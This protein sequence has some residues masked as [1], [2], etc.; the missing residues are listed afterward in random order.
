MKIRILGWKYEHIR[1]MES[2][3]VS[4]EREDGEIYPHSLIMMP[5]GT[6]KTTTLYLIRAAL[7]GSAINWK[8]RDVISY[9][10]VYSQEEEGGFTLKVAFGEDIYYYVL[11]LDYESGRAWYETGSAM[12]AGGLEEGWRLPLALR[13]I[14]N[15]EGFVNRFIFDGEQARKTL[16]TGS[17]EAENSIVYL[18]QL[19]KLTDL[20]EQVNKVVQNVQEQNSGGATEHSVKIFRSRAEKRKKRWEDLGFEEREI[21][22]Q[23]ESMEAENQRLQ[24]AYQEILA[25]DQQMQAEQEQL[26][27]EQERI[28]GEKGAVVSMLTEKMRR[29]YNLQLDIHTRMKALLENMQILK[30]P[31]TTAREFFKELADSDICVCGRPIGKEEKSKILENA[32]K[33]LGQDE[34]IAVNAIK[35][36][37]RE[38]ERDTDLEEL[39]GRLQGLM[40]QE[41]QAQSGL[42]RLTTVLADKGHGEI[43][44]IK[45]KLEK[46]EEE[47]KRLKVQLLRLTTTDYISNTGLN[48]DNNIPLAQK[49]WRE[50]QD[51]FLKASGTYEFTRKAERLNSYIGSVKERTL[52][53]LKTYLVRET[54]ER[55]NTLI[56]NDRILI[57][58]IDGHLVLEGKEGASEGQTLALAY[59]YIGTLF[60]HSRFEFPFLVDS[61]AAAMDLDV[62]REVAE[63]LPKLFGQTI[64]F[65]TSGEKSGFVDTFFERQDVHYLTIKGTKDEAAQCIPG[66]AFFEKYQEKE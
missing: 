4:L 63:V 38:Y 35:N 57:K 54:N 22:R 60:A 34:L 41:H 61:P 62:R 28:K 13:G 24:Q 58:R 50:A 20:M 40:E 48:A 17:Q 14:L 66:R 37:L 11:H 39:E 31:K 21:R 23:L 29:P 44:Q 12:M 9:R 42:N 33:Y 36:A 16:N 53:K 25:Q 55:L 52:K 45:E 46:L 1:R 15:S 5:N 10:P 43:L 49:S 30:L 51:S 59:A 26:L 18:Y 64:I 6:G 3:E 65:V 7:D 19:N 32:E 47:S 2:L 27:Q 8:K 56:A